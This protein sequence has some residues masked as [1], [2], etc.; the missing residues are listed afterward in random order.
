M[1]VYVYFVFWCYCLLY[2]VIDYMLVVSTLYIDIRLL[3]LLLTLSL[4]YL[5]M[6]WPLL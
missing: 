3:V 4:N 2:I 5:A 6:G 1:L